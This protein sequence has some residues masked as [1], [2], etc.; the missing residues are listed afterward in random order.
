MTEYERQEPQGGEVII[1]AP[2]CAVDQ[3]SGVRQAKRTP[4]LRNLTQ[5]T[6]RRT[7]IRYFACTAHGVSVL[8]Q[9]LS[10]SAT[11]AILRACRYMT[12]SPT[13]EEK[14]KIRPLSSAIYSNRCE[15]PYRQA[16]DRL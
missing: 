10:K 1:A 14:G 11:M 7:R 8:V 5:F 15:L 16:V 12:A 4:Q 2:P 6:A 9:L 3:P 13:V